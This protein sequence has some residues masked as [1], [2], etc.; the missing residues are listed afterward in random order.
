MIKLI[1]FKIWCEITKNK[2]VLCSQYG[3]DDVETILYV[4]LY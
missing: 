2:I 1:N 3:K 4:I